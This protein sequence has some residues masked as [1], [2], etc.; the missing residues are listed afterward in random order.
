M[1]FDAKEF[2]EEYNIQNWD[3]GPNTQS[4]WINIQCPFCDDDSN[5]GGFNLNDGHY[6]CWRC[7]W[8]STIDAIS[9]LL[10][11]RFHE[12]IK[13]KDKFSNY[14]KIGIIKKNKPSKQELEIN[15]S[16]KLRKAQIKYLVSRDFDPHY[17]SQKYDLRD[18]GI[19]GE[20]SFRI[21]FPIYYNKK[22]VSYQGRDYSGKI[23]PR[24]KACPKHKEA[25]HHKDIL[26]NID[27]AKRD[28]CVVVEGIFDV[29]RLGDGAVC[30]FGTSYTIKQALELKN[31]FKKVYIIYDPNDEKAQEKARNLGTL[32]QS[33]GI[34]CYTIDIPDED[35]AEMSQDNANY[36]MKELL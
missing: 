32:L 8:H 33:T 9:R 29:L 30:T 7:G 5:H 19:A 10:N 15:Y 23:W 14:Q 36:L 34:N 12:A 17:I 18:G 3:T 31:R 25:I 11:I 26:Y 28:C 24:Y 21:V 1:I 22:I 20:Q 35:P 4:E 16:K 13:I 2:L 27:C 6:N